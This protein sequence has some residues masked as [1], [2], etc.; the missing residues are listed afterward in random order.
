MYK[1]NDRQAERQRERETKKRDKV[2]ERQI[3]RGAEIQR[4]RDKKRDSVRETESI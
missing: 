1:V 4:G 2:T 3:L